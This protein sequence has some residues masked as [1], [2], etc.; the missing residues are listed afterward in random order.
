MH[1]A[2]AQ[3]LAAWFKTVLFP[4]ETPTWVKASRHF[5]T[6]VGLLAS[7]MAVPLSYRFGEL[8]AKDFL[9]DHVFKVTCNEDAVEAFQVYN[10]IVGTLSTAAILGKV[11]NSLMEQLCR[12]PPAAQLAVTDQV[13]KSSY[14]RALFLLNAL[15]SLA[16]ATP[17]SYAAYVTLEPAMKKGVGIF[18]ASDVYT[19][20]SKNCWAAL[21]LSGRFWRNRKKALYESSEDD[22]ERLVLIQ[23]LE[24][25]HE[26]LST[27]SEKRAQTLHQQHIS[28][29]T[30]S[31]SDQE[32][33]DAMGAFFLLGRTH[34]TGAAEAVQKKPWG[35]RIFGYFGSFLAASGAAATYKLGQDGSQHFINWLSS[36]Q[37]KATHNVS[38]FL[39][40]LAYLYRIALGVHA[41]QWSF[42]QAYE[43]VKNCSKKQ[44]PAHDLLNA[45]D[46][47]IAGNNP[48]IDPHAP[49][50]VDF[51]ET[52][53]SEKGLN[54]FL[55]SMLV[56]LI[57][58]GGGTPRVTMTD[59]AYDNDKWYFGPLCFFAFMA[60]FPTNYW[61]NRRLANAVFEPN[62]Y[63]S[64]LIGY[65]ERLSV[66][67]YDMKK[68][69]VT[70][71][72]RQV[73]LNS[74]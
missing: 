64:K 24:G 16:S 26:Y 48:G 31:S 54:A 21:N 58:L 74:E 37:S 9:C 44:D 53:P 63:S 67:I 17:E 72:H 47:N 15:C 12:T 3:Q 55:L 34:D 68:P 22:N 40:I 36:K 2:E 57:S 1:T 6:V 33:L 71:L 60:A 69:V 5:D 62:P 70:E 50:D 28:T 8:L 45:Q 19:L 46:A 20:T 59:I 30:A 35:K 66:V 42:E 10:T 29:L 14:H 4:P 49:T 32:L 73:N 61:V 38:V 7:A 25:A 51:D 43:Y 11:A 13:D 65:A 23:L 18:V 56:L 39:G 41:S 52:Q 27:I